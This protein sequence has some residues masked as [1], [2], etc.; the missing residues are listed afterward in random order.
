MLYYVCI[1][2]LSTNR[3][4]TE[5]V[6]RSPQFTAEFRENAADGAYNTGYEENMNSSA[7]TEDDRSNGGIVEFFYSRRRSTCSRRTANTLKTSET[8]ATPSE[9]LKQTHSFDINRYCALRMDI[10]DEDSSLDSEEKFG[11]SIATDALLLHRCFEAP[12]DTN[13][14][15]IHSSLDSEEGPDDSI[16]TDD[17][18][19][20]HRHFEA[21]QETIG[22]QI[23]MSKSCNNLQSDMM[24]SNKGSLIV[25][26]GAPYHDDDDDSTNSPF[27]LLILK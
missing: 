11:D 19:L 9:L 22:N 26:W 21:H 8:S 16:A 13:G 14:N 12:Q 17:A 7:R 5:G 24:M 27:P 3:G 1:I 10:N 18:L 23:H 15:Q 6:C 4:D 25:E 20:L 2:S